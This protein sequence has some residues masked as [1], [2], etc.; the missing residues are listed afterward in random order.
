[1]RLCVE[2]TH[3][4]SAKVRNVQAVR[5]RIEALIIVPRG[6]AAEWIVADRAQRDRLVCDQTQDEYPDSEHTSP[7]SNFRGNVVKARHRIRLGP[8]ANSACWIGIVGGF[9]NRPTIEESR[10]VVT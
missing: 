3:H 1:M 10:E 6:V 5:G 7:L 2:D 9:H 8:Q 4:T